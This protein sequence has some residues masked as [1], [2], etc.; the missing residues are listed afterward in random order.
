[1][2]RKLRPRKG[3]TGQHAAYTGAVGEVTVDTTKNAIVVHDGTT[4]GGHPAAKEANMN[5][6]GVGLGNV[7]NTA[8]LNKPISNATQSALDLKANRI[9]AVLTGTPTAPTQFAGDNS[10]K[11]AT[12]AYVDSAFDTVQVASQIDPSSASLAVAPHTRV[13]YLTAGSLV[14][15]QTIDLTSLPDGA[16]ITIYSTSGITAL[17]ISG[18]TLIGTLSTL[19]AGGAARVARA[20]TNL[21]LGV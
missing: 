19:A 13:L 11:I 8:D 18:G 21:L 5:K 1:M 17:T 2:A 20:G 3:T 4:A 9:N 14:A 15:A 7:D 12:T 6:A 16:V 10:D